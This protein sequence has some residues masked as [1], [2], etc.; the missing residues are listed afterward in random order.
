MGKAVAESRKLRETFDCTVIPIRG[1]ADLARPRRFSL[2]KL[3][4]ALDVFRALFAAL[5]KGGI[6][7]VYMTAAINGSAAFRDLCL[8]LLCRTF[9]AR[10]IIHLHMKGLRA[11]YQASLCYRILYRMMFSGADV[12]HLSE[13]FYDDVSPVVARGKFHVVA[14][15]V[16]DILNRNCDESFCSKQ[17]AADPP[18]ILFMSNRFRDKGPL[19]LLEASDRLHADG[20]AHRVMFVGAGA[21]PDVERTLN[22]AAARDPGRVRLHGGRYGAER[23]AL[24][25][26]ASIFA[27]PTFYSFECQPLVLIEAMAAGLPLISTPEGAISDLVGSDVGILCAQR[28]VGA[29]AVAMRRLIEDP[30]LRGRMGRVARQRY[31]ADFSLDIFESRLIATLSSLTAKCPAPA[32]GRQPDPLTNFGREGPVS[33]PRYR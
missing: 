12:I 8:L 31:C 7:A 4:T 16:P 30:Q 21:D 19:D 24:L 15:G 18:T 1:N 29:L 14:N 26:T 9:G 20:V 2:E 33:R 6:D 11:R 10:R 32:P 22:E 23:D 13:S 25:Q 28:D 17:C 27:L 3:R 5:R